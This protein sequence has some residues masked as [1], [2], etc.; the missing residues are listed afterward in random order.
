[1]GE[2][3]SF[4]TLASSL[5]SCTLGIQALG[6]KIRNLLVLNSDLFSFYFLVYK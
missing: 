5:L 3:L 1:M 4:L 2:A 6:N